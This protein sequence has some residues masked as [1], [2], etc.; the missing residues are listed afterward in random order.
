MTTITDALRQAIQ[1]QLYDVHTALAGVIV[2][3]DY[4][5]QKAEIQPSLKGTWTKD[6]RTQ[7]IEVF[8]WGGGGISS[9]ANSGAGGTGANGKIIIIE[10][11]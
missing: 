7:W 2:S 5:K 4:T 11:F 10:H 6:P 8:L 9:Q 3:Y 1:F